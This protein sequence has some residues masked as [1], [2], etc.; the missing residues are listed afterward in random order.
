MVVSCD[1]S[2]TEKG[3]DWT[4]D[5]TLAG[6]DSVGRP[7]LSVETLWMVEVMLHVFDFGMCEMAWLGLEVSQL[8][9]IAL[10][11]WI[12]ALQYFPTIRHAEAQTLKDE[13]G[14]ESQKEQQKAEE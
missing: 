13:K 10:V 8:E 1:A 6:R 3:V 7:L 4:T 2:G 11:F 12:S 5:E 14:A 9:S